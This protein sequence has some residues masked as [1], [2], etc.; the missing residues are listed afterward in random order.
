V[1]NH[2][3]K[4]VGSETARIR[5]SCGSER[6]HLG[7]RPS[8]NLS[9]GTARTPKLSRRDHGSGFVSFGEK[10]SDLQGRGSQHRRRPACNSLPNPIRLT[11]GRSCLNSPAVCF[12][13]SFVQFARR[14][15]NEAVDVLGQKPWIDGDAV[16]A[17]AIPGCKMLTRGC[18]SQARS[19]PRCRPELS[20]IRKIRSRERY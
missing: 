5:R 9:R 17:D 12:G 19:Q 3:T 16:A 7:R 13:I 20:A 15:K 10:P 14:P 18:C 8:I 6:N 2:R 4:A 11:A 1:I